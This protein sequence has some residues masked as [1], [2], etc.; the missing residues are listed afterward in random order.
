MSI[1]FKRPS[2]PLAID[3]SKE[4]GAI[5]RHFKKRSVP[6]SETGKLLLAS[7]NIANLGAQGRPDQALELIA[8]ILKRFDLIAVQEINENFNTFLK[9]MKFLGPQFDYVMNDTAGN[10]ERLGFI[11]RKSNV[12][13]RNLFGEIALRKSEYPKRNVIVRYR[14]DG[15]D[16]TKQ[17]KNVRFQPF[18]RNPFIGSFASD[19]FDLSL[20]NVHL[21]FGD[22]QNS[23][24]EKEQLRYCRRVLEICALAKWASRRTDLAK[25]YDQDIVLLGDM[26][27]PRMDD[28]ESTYQALTSY[29]AVPVRLLENL[30]R[31][32]GTNINNDRSYDQ[33]AF[34]PGR[35]CGKVLDQ[36]VFDFDNAAFKDRWD[37]ICSEISSNK[38]RITRFNSYVKHYLSDHRVIWVQLDVS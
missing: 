16:K 38:K 2:P 35:I 31:T 10:T 12:K 6:D 27:V 14:D 32:G 22:F 7:W 9:V 33:L 24:T 21:Y 8:H 23:K 5:T 29:G 1:P 19:N 34:V 30:E 37:S 20:V 36:G 25:T 26:N 13:T 3:V 11:Y 15:V 28:A 18:D 17:Y 4:K